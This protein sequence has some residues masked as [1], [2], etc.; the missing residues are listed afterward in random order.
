MMM[1]VICGQVPSNWHQTDT[2]L[3]FI[4][5]ALFSCCISVKLSYF[6]FHIRLNSEIITIFAKHAFKK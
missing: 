1:P 3:Y 2:K 5:P 4:E 6:R